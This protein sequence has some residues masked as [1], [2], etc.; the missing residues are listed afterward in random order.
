MG[1][2]ES[3]IMSLEESKDVLS[4]EVAVD[5]NREDIVK[6]MDAI[7]NSPEALKKMREENAKKLFE[8]GEKR[9]EGQKRIDIM[10]KQQLEIEKGT[11]VEQALQETRKAIHE[12]KNADEGIYLPKT[13]PYLKNVITKNKKI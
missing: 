13:E 7:D 6:K 1:N 12:S 9:R 4:E 8:E 11:E 10:K 2:P 3:R 5:K